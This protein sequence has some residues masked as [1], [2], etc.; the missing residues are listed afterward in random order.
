[1]AIN[2]YNIE[3]PEF[4]QSWELA[5][6]DSKSQYYILKLTFGKEKTTTR[7]DNNYFE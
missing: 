2:K 7:N 3:F 5:I 1:M 4:L 6:F